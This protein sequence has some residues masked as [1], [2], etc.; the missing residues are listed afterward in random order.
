MLQLLEETDEVVSTYETVRAAA[1]RQSFAYD[2][3]AAMF[4]TLRMESQRETMAKPSV[5]DTAIPQNSRV[6]KDKVVKEEEDGKGSTAWGLLQHFVLGLL[7][8]LANNLI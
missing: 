7:E 3:L 4:S 1:E 8:S 2:E 6:Q 5:T